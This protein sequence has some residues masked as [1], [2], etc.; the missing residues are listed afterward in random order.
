VPTATFAGGVAV[1]V[2]GVKAYDWLTSEDEADVVSQA[3][4][5]RKTP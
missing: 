3:P 5:S 2:A 1:G 4:A